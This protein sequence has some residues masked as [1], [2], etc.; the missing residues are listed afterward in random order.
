[1]DPAPLGPR[2]VKGSLGVLQQ[3]FDLAVRDRIIS[4]NPVVGVRRPSAPRDASNA[5]QVWTLNQLG[6]FLRTVD[7]EHAAGRL[8][9]AQAVAMRLDAFGMRREEV[10][11]VSW[12]AVDLDRG[13]LAVLQARVVHDDGTA[14]LLQP[15][16]TRRSRRWVPFDMLA[17]GTGRLLRELRMASGMPDVGLAVGEGHGQQGAPVRPAGVP[18]GP[19]V[20]LDEAGRWIDPRRLSARF[21][22]LSQRAGLPK[23][24]MHGTRHTIGTDLAHD[25]SVSDIV[26]A[27][28]IGDDVGTFLSTYAQ[29]RD[30]AMTVAAARLGARMADAMGL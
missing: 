6:A 14:D 17:P 16:K 3:A 29:R 4:T 28:I 8:P 23:I 7:E 20:V 9:L 11:G 5:D 25:P 10:C 1:M 13:R 18:V 19:L 26:A 12:D 30:D 21:Q 15:P 22:Q 24:R 2:A 27:S